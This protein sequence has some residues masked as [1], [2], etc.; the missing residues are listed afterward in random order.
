MGHIGGWTE[1]KLNARVELYDRKEPVVQP[2]TPRG[3]EL[4]ITNRR[5]AIWIGKAAKP[6]TI[7]TDCAARIAASLRADRETRARVPVRAGDR[8]TLRTSWSCF[9][10]LICDDEL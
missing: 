8:S 9:A 10:A 6:N 4:P 2:V 3:A 1:T 5:S 7:R